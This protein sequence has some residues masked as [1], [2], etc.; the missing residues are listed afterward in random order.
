VIFAGCL[1]MPFAPGC[2]MMDFD[3]N[4][5]VVMFDFVAFLARVDGTPADCNDN[6]VID[7]EEIL[8]DPLLDKNGDGVLDVCACPA[9]FGGN[10]VVN[11]EDL[12]QLLGAWGP[13]PGHAADLNGD[14]EVDAAD[15]AMLLG[16][17]G[18]CE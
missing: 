3:G 7:M 1:E 11:A 13:N 12:A 10:G 14:D 17:W 8:L 16:A 18:P 2:E 6:G 4:S 15:L 9:D 5:A